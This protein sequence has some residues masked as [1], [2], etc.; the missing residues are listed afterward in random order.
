VRVVIDTNVL[1]DLWLFD[2]PAARPLRAALQAGRLRALRSRDCDAE[3]AEVL[4][5]SRFGLDEEQCARLLAQWHACSEAIERIAA[6]PF[7]CADPDD[8]KFLDAAFSSGAD[9][10]LTRD[11]GLLRLA[12]RA[13]ALGLRIVPPAAAPCALQAAR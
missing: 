4:A 11:K 6:A 9:A 13:A 8:Q 1:L 12:R 10:L 7:A 5:R 2:D 3:L